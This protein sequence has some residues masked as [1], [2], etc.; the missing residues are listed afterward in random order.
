MQVHQLL[1]EYTRTHM[2]DSFNQIIL[3]TMYEYIVCMCL[4]FLVCGQ[5]L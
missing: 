3:H 4:L 5:V 2:N 1:N